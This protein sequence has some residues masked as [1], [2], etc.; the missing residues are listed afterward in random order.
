MAGESEE[1]LEHYRKPIPISEQLV[2]EDAQR[3]EARRKMRAFKSN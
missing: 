1:A 3:V 2:S